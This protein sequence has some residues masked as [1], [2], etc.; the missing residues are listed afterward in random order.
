MTTESATAAAPWTYSKTFSLLDLFIYLHTIQ[1]L[2]FSLE[3]LILTD[4]SNSCN[5]SSQMFGQDR[6]M[7]SLGPCAWAVCGMTK[8]T[9]C[10]I[11]KKLDE[12]I[13]ELVKLDKGILIPPVVRANVLIHDQIRN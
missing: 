3:P 11:W 8:M 6:L 2:T 1:I 4:N 7:L 5:T 13:P 10:P 12:N 9:C